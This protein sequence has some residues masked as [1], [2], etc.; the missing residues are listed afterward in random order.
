MRVLVTG[1]GGMLARSVIAALEKSGHDALGL[2][3]R[4]ADVTQAGA[5]DH[6]IGRFQPDWIF[7]LAAWTQ[8]DECERDPDRAFLVNALGSRQMALAA[9]ASDAALLA[10]STDYVFSGEA[11]RPYREYDPVDP[12]SVYGAS[13]WA[14]E[15][16]VRELQPRH[17][18]VRTA[19][20]YGRGGTNFIDT[21][22]RKARAGESLRVVDDQRGSPTSTADLAL[23]LIRLAERGAFGTFH[24]TNSGDCTWY[25]LAA[26][27]LNRAGLEVGLERTDSGTLA[28]PAPRPRYSVL[29]L[30]AF[31]QVSGLKMTSWS[32][33]VDRYLAR[34]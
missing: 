2:K 25:D 31:E 20:L 7:H 33:A 18:I 29:N 3:R 4:D 26:H 16:A 22:L 23:G 5:L 1:A 34:D 14:G 17:V 19:W 32:D 30:Q 27:V 6:A 12:R 13:K 10:I 9:A 21:I 24:C 11:S 15:Q 28:R 8:V